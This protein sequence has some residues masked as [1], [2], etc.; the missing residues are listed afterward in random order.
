MPNDPRYHSALGIA[1]AGLGKKEEAIKE[2]LKAVE[3]LPMS[4]DATY[5][6]TY[7]YDLAINYT[8]N[9]EYDLAL[10]QVEYLLS[11]PSWM[12]ITWLEWEIRFAPLLTHPRFLE[13]KEKYSENQ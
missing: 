8:M 9:G 4:K 5:G 1:Y 6:T 12:S 10:D 7:V 3:L 11:V 13:L 2:G